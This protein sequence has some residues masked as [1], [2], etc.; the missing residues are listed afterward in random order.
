MIKQFDFY[1][2]F[3]SPYT[4]LAHKEIRRVEKEYSTKIHYKPVFL[5]G[6]LKT[7]GNKANIDIPIKAKY[8]IK[9]CKLWADKYKINF[10]FNNYF[11]ISTLNL[12]RGVLVTAQKKKNHNFINSIFD[13]IWVNNLNLNNDLV[14]KKILI[15][16]K[17]NPK[18]FLQEISEQNI[19]DDLKK[20]TDQAIKIGIFGL[21]TF[22]VNK[23]LFWGQD[24]LEFALNEA[25]K[26]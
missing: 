21:P 20:R 24:R 10:K 12:M 6:I 4:F 23:K 15:N 25:K 7:L 16:L 9:D 18:T 22:L 19:K 26:K 5:G 13:A 11:P 3:A 2:D 8:M 14:I 17:I 1:F